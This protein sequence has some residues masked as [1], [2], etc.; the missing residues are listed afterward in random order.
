VAGL[1]DAIT[2][3]I[4][5]FGGGLEEQDYG[6]DPFGQLKNDLDGDYIIDRGAVRKPEVTTEPIHTIGR[7]KSKTNENVSVFPSARGPELM[8]IEP[9]SF[10]EDATPVIEYLQAGKTIVLNFHLLDKEQAQ[11]LVDFVSG[12]TTALKGHQQ[13]IADTVFIFAP[14]NTTISADSIK[15]KASMDG[16]WTAR[17]Y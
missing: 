10:A 2:N 13:K 3:I 17:P 15:T 9:R 16:L 5:F 11:R 12:A 4:G 6:N 8:V 7:T 1:Q 14:T